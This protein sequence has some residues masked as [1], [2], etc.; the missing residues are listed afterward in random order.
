MAAPQEA[1][2]DARVLKQ[3]ARLGRIQAEQMSANITQFNQQVVAN[4]FLVW[5][6]VLKPEIRS[7]LRS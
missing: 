6:P 2:L 4:M 7:L 1:V 3:L 5:V